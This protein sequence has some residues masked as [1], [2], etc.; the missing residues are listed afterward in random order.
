M[1][2]QMST[3]QARARAIA[4]RDGQAARRL[5]QVALMS[6]ALLSLVAYALSKA[7]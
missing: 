3:H 6:L 2:S 4:A 7:G 1:N 5:Q